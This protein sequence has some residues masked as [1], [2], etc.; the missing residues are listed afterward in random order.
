MG[1]CQSGSIKTVDSTIHPEVQKF[2]GDR[3]KFTK[4]EMQQLDTMTNR[5]KQTERHHEDLA[6][7]MID[8]VRSDLSEPPEPKRPKKFRSTGTQFFETELEEIRHGSL[9]KSEIVLPEPQ[10]S[11]SAPFTN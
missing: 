5:L 6:E 3:I 8:R 1:I 9:S 10:P 2:A 11:N 7:N 4:W